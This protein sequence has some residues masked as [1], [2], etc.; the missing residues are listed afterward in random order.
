MP[1]PAVMA[2]AKKSDVRMVVIVYW[3]LSVKPRR[4][5]FTLKGVTIY[6]NCV[7]RKLS[8][9]FGAAWVMTIKSPSCYVGDMEVARDLRLFSNDTLAADDMQT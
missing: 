9:M 8:S 2:V 3:Q 5:R 4:V 6:A 7:C 1:P